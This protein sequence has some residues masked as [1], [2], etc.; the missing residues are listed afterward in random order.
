MKF[1]KR[2]EHVEAITFDELIEYG[3]GHYREAE[4]D[5]VDGILKM[6][7]VYNGTRFTF[8]DGYLEWFS[9]MGSYYRASHG[10]IIVFSDKGSVFQ[11]KEAHFYELYEACE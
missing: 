2:P 11:L 10:S 4:G 1:R 5:S 8:R 3:K 6:M 9:G 7:F